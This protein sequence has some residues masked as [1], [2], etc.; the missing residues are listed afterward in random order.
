MEQSNEHKDEHNKVSNITQQLV[1]VSLTQNYVS[2]LTDTMREMNELF[3]IR[4][5]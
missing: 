1:D 5:F 2:T 4:M 3:L